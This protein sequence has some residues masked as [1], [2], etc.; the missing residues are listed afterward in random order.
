M[1]DYSFLSPIDFQK[2]CGDIIQ[3]R[4]N[5]T[6]ECFALGKD[7]GIDYRGFKDGK[8]IIV[9]V[10]STKNYN[11]LKSELKNVE[12]AKVK[13]LNPD[14]YILMVAMP[15][16]PNQKKEILEIFKD[17]IVDN[18][19]LIHGAD[20]EGYLRRPE[21]SSVRKF[22]QQKAI[23]NVVGPHEYKIVDDHPFVNC[24]WLYQDILELEK[25]YVETSCFER[26]KRRIE[27]NNNI[28]ILT[29]DPGSG[30][31]TNAKMLIAYLLDKKMVD[32]V[33][34]L[35]SYNDFFKYYDGEKRQIFFFDDFWG[36]TFR[37]NYFDSNIERDL[38]AMLDLVSTNS[39]SYLIMTTREYVLK[40][41]LNALHIQG[42]REV[43]RRIYHSNS[44]FTKLE[45]TKILI[46]H[47]LN[48]N[49][50]YNV[51]SILLYNVD[52]ITEMMNYSPRTISY[53]I[54]QHHDMQASNGYDFYDD[55]MEYLNNPFG[56]FEN[57]FYKL[58]KS[59]RIITYIMAISNPPIY[60]DKLKECFILFVDGMKDIKLRD[61]NLYVQEL[62][63][64]F[65]KFDNELRAIDFVNHSIHDFINEQLERDYLDYKKEIIHSIIYFNQYTNLLLSD[66]IAV[67]KENYKILI[68]RLMDNFDEMDLISVD[69]DE[70][71]IFDYPDMPFVWY[72]KKIWHSINIAEKYNDRIFMDF[73]VKK[74]LELIDY[75]L[76]A[77][78]SYEDKNYT[79]I[80]DLLKRFEKFGYEFDYKKIALKFFMGRK[81]LFEFACVKYGPEAFQKEIKN[82]F[83]ENRNTI[84]PLLPEYLK[85][86]LEVLS[87]EGIGFE[88][89]QLLDDFPDICT[90]FDIPYSK[91]LA[92]I[93]DGNKIK[94]KCNTYFNS[95]DE[96]VKLSAD[97]RATTDYLM[98]IKDSFYEE[99]LNKYE[100]LVVFENEDFKEAVI[101]KIRQE[102]KSDRYDSIF[103]SDL[104]KMFL[105]LIISY[106]KETDDVDFSWK[107]YPKLVKFIVEKTDI[108]EKSL[109]AYAFYKEVNGSYMLSKKHLAN[110]FSFSQKEINDLIK[111]GVFK[112]I[113]NLVDFTDENFE[114]Y[115]R[116]MYAVKDG[117]NSFDEY[118]QYFNGTV[119]CLSG[120]YV[121]FEYFD[122]KNF[123]KIFLKKLLEYI[124]NDSYNIFKGRI[125]D[126]E[127]DCNTEYGYSYTLASDNYLILSDL[128]TNFDGESFEEKLIDYIKTTK[129]FAN[130]NEDKIKIIE[131]YDNN[132]NNKDGKH[133]DD[134][135]MKYYNWAKGF[136]KKII[137]A[138]GKIIEF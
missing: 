78:H 50:D 73:L 54:S 2:M 117:N 46:S 89:D 100:A 120:D 49:L 91:D 40:Q 63:N 62:E 35:K 3:I 20:I 9:Q 86:E 95:K 101:D 33:I 11:T 79:A 97:E 133:V 12:L 112:E 84:I 110:N 118:K 88:Y 125:M 55:L 121:M 113:Y 36:S 106:I 98:K 87:E 137:Q 92:K 52:K 74:T 96:V 72:N 39:N 1:D 7:Q 99:C 65:T 94:Y 17:Y 10:K 130:N 114:T 138:D 134:L 5:I 69:G 93:I 28:I 8:T 42:G 66:D 32:E 104:S 85:L 126:I 26:V 30:K 71:D 56:Y 109:Y 41:G 51:I 105:N 23:L 67:D 13:K 38:F 29:G 45:K 25:Y 64:T 43:E 31:T 82:L 132:K 77:D 136:Y 24:R 57:I 119:A 135:C 6:F 122:T 129:W 44:D 34:D 127:F 102:L 18:L 48:S 75:Y 90:Y 21:Y 115:L 103:A 76:S 81:Y 68:K 47:V 15:L 22:F 19:D 60:I 14:R 116:V 61:F 37:F 80:P 83:N 108:M 124:M 4:E 131:F 128:Y 58:S 70:L 123:N 59:S 107:L 27:D 111:I 53:Y 16:L